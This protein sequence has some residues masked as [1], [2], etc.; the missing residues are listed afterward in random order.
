MEEN[1]EDRLELVRTLLRSYGSVAVAFSGG[2][3]STLLVRIAQE[4]L[5]HDAI[6][7]T[8]DSPFFPRAE[9]QAAEALIRE[10]GL[11]FRRVVVEHLPEEVMSNPRNRCYLCKRRI[12]E[13]VMLTAGEEGISVVVEGSN[14]D[15]RGDYRPGLQALRELGI[16]SPFLEAGL[17]K[18]AIRELSRRF[19]LATWDKPP[20]ACL[21]SRIPYGEPIT[22]EALRQVEEAE[23]FLHNFG[24]RQCRVRHHGTVA[25][26]EV[27]PEERQCF[28]STEFM[29]KMAAGLRKIGFHH[30]AL[31]LEGYRTGKM[32]YHTGDK[33]AR[34]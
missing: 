6:A 2:S 34:A 8:V 21:A 22:F 10:L 20:A 13:T 28:F 19:G 18:I 31:D 27:S 26:I 4:V 17:D 1:L 11:R 32:N 16:R 23:Q 14:T 5:G 7:V 25:R 15:D 9:L 12:M 30:V 29:E 33:V 24:I 3:D